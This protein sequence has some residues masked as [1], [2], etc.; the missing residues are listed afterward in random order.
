MESLSWVEKTVGSLA[1]LLEQSR[2][3]YCI[4]SGWKSL[5]YD[6]PSDLDIVVH[7]QD[8]PKLESALLSGQGWEVIQMNPESFFVLT[9]QSEG[10]SRFVFLDVM[11]GFY[12]G[13]D[14]RVYL[15]ADEILEKRRK[16]NGLFLVSPDIEL[17]YRLFKITSK[18]KIAGKDRLQL[19]ELCSFP[20]E[21]AV[22]AAEILFGKLWAERIIRW[23][24]DENWSCFDENMLQLKRVMRRRALKRNPLNQL[25][26]LLL[27]AGR[28][29]VR[30]IYPRGFFIAVLGPD[31]SG[32]SLLV[33]GLRDELGR[34]FKGAAV[35]HVWP[36]AP[37]IMKRA[38]R[39]VLG[40]R[41]DPRKNHVNFSPLPIP[42]LLVPLYFFI[43]YWSS[44]L[45]SVRPLLVKSSLVL[46]DRYYNDLLVDP[47]RY[48]YTGSGHA[49]RF[50]YALV[51]KPDF[52]LVID[53]PAE[54]TFKRKQDLTI[55]EIRRQRKAYK[56][57]ADKL[58]DARL[59]DGAGAAGDVLQEAVDAVI[60]EL[61]QR[62]L[63]RRGVWSR[64]WRTL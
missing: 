54:Q 12:N 27:A 52:F 41:Y 62:Y 45:L 10:K 37:R 6:L 7:P 44:Y 17:V 49:A 48:G 40:K 60:K 15:S 1:R 8:L 9:V 58:P 29:C 33:Q 56:Q 2:I 26:Y 14:K 31:G 53:S 61:R 23:I 50:I 36:V 21:G 18:A 13:T 39:L 24:E 57:L 22:S 32:K 55:Q 51:P 59:I 5:P 25:V 16:W 64:A 4:A 28:V 35:F 34:V 42:S 63:R 38:V 19:Y 30:W 46:Y 3:R 47:G 43:R 20:G 11:T